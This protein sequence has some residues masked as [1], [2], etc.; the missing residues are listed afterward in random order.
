LHEAWLEFDGLPLKWHYPLGLLYDLFSGA[1]PWNALGAIG[2]LRGRGKGEEE[3]DG[4][5]DEDVLPWSLTLRYGEYP[6]HQIF[7]LDGEGKVLLDA[8]INSVK[9][10]SETKFVHTLAVG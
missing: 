9:E 10:V 1:R 8:Y 5:R 4:R 6:A 3:G 7:P 2:T